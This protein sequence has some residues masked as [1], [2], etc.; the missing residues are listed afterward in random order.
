MFIY[1]LIDYFIKLDF[2]FRKSMPSIPTKSRKP[3]NP[4]GPGSYNID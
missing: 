1:R 3:V 4:P 2:H